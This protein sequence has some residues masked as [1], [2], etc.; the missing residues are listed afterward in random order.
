MELSEI[1]KALRNCKVGGSCFDCPL[2]SSGNLCF[3]NLNNIAADAL[4]MQRNH[5]VALTER[6]KEVPENAEM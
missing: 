6:Q 4:E 3:E 5:I 1:I 2:W